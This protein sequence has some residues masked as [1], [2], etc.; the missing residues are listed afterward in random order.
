MFDSGVAPAPNRRLSTVEGPAPAVLHDF[1]PIV[2]REIRVT[3]HVLNRPDAATTAAP[4]GRTSARIVGVDL[5]RAIAL[6]GMFA[7]HVGPGETDHALDYLF[8]VPHGRASLLFVL[9]AGVGVSMLA[10][11]PRL[12]AARTRGTLLWRAAL[13]LPVGLAL[14]EL[15]HSVA[16][17]LQQY[18][19]LFVV[20][21]ALTGLPGR[22][23]LRIALA[24]VPIGSTLYLRGL[25]AAPDVYARTP[26][27]LTDD[28]SDIIHRLVLSG[29]YPLVTWIA[30]FVFGMWLGRLDLRAKR[31]RAWL[32][33]GGAAAALLAAGGSRALVSLLGDPGEA[34][35]FGYLILDYPHSQMPLWLL[36]S[37][38]AAVAVLGAALYV[39]EALP[40]LARPLVW[41]G[42]LT[43]TLYVGHLVALVFREQFDGDSA[44]EAAWV[45][46][47]FTV[48]SILVA[49]LWRA[50]LPRGPL[51]MVLQPPWQWRRSRETSG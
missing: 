9:V 45:L 22:W 47:A 14:Q 46:A 42:Q 8:E 31:T 21:I 32:F 38:A 11:S 39:A 36:G 2:A 34:S 15:D 40:R 19:L 10:A 33:F 24:A 49:S 51:E 4:T 43:L 13:L 20:A 26:V 18:A 5:A 3:E 16:V 1:V 44:S 35:G 25:I 27:A 29:P 7:V 41:T 50:W 6:I 28:V 37:T 48:A 30:P 23:L 12:S 17:I